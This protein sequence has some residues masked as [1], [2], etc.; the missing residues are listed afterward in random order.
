MTL[1]QLIDSIGSFPEMVGEVGAFITHSFVG[2]LLLAVLALQFGP[3]VLRGV[4]R[5]TGFRGFGGGRDRAVGEKYW[6]YRGQELEAQEDLLVRGM[7]KAGA[8]D[9]EF[10]KYRPDDWSWD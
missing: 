2:P 4:L 5:A 9:S 6:N 7:A 8:F 1:T 10:E 3:P